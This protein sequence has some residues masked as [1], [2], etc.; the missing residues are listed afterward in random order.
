[1]NRSIP[2][3]L[4]IAIVS[5][6]V[7]IF[8]K[9]LAAFSVGPLVLVDAALT[10][11]L[12]YGIIRGYKWAYVLTILSIMFGIA[13]GFTKS[14]QDGLAVLACDSLVLIPVLFYTDYFFP[15]LETLNIYL[16]EN[17]HRSLPPAKPL[18]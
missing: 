5:T 10:A 9:C 12:L 1:M 15:K 3:P 14:V 18:Q 11:I 13:M 4:W 6:G 16:S 8:G 17:N 2:G 7:M